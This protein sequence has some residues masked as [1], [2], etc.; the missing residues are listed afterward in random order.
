MVDAGSLADEI[1]NLASTPAHQ[2]M[3][4]A[5]QQQ[6]LDEWLRVTDERAR[7]PES[8]VVPDSEM[9][10]CLDSLSHRRNNAVRLR[11]IEA[12]IRLMQE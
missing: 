8:A 7:Q 10:V 2:A 9:R 4:V 11:G 6:R 3:L 5:L 12:D 1:R